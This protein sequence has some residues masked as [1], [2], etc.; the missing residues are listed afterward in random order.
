M[1]IVPERSSAQK[2]RS[3]EP[4]SLFT[5]KKQ[6][7]KVSSAPLLLPFQKIRQDIL[8]LYIY[9]YMYGKTEHSL[10]PRVLD[11]GFWWYYI[12]HVYIMPITTCSKQYIV[13][14]DSSRVCINRRSSSVMY[15]RYMCSL[16]P[17]IAHVHNLVFTNV[18]F[19]HYSHDSIYAPQWLEETTTYSSLNQN[20]SSYS[21]LP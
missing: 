7:E 1:V 20:P 17:S 9:L 21:N 2:R 14:V 13:I 3:A 19:S 5:P 10:G 11:Q 12:P 4:P 8:G 15:T 6:K 18:N 16:Y